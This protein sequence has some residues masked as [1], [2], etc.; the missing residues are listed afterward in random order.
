MPDQ[1]PYSERYRLIKL[2]LLPK[3]AVKKQ[4]KPI[5]KKSVKKIAEEKEERASRGP[6]GDTELQK[7]MK[8]AIK[9]MRGVCSETGL[10]TETKIFKYACMSIAHILPRQKVK[11]VQY[12]PLN[13][14]E[15]DVGMHVKFDKMS[16]YRG[17][18]GNVC[19]G[20]NYDSWQRNSDGNYVVGP[21]YNSYQRNPDGKLVCGG[22][23]AKSHPDDCGESS[24]ITVHS[25]DDLK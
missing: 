3:E 5:A 6:D 15:L 9:R 17:S 18:D 25:A 21:K 8:N 22:E 4:P 20:G 12:H 2:G 13:W 19:V 10:R 1:L 14:V 7:F 16:W 24:L 11:S 23:Y